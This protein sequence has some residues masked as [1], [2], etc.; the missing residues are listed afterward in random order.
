MADASRTD[1]VRYILKNIASV[2]QAIADEKRQFAPDSWPSPL[3]LSVPPRACRLLV[4]GSGSATVNRLSLCGGTE[5][6]SA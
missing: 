3:P 1:I 5:T 4:P 6:T 2:A